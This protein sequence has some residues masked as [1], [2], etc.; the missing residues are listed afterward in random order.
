MR[1][2]PVMTIL[3]QLLRVVYRQNLFWLVLMTSERA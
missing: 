1:N 2:I 3:G